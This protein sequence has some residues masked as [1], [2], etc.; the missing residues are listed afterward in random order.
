MVD[1]EIIYLPWN[2][3]LENTGKCFGC[4]DRHSRQRSDP[5]EK[6]TQTFTLSPV[7]VIHTFINQPHNSTVEKMTDWNLNKHNY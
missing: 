4:A 2:L 3:L 1:Y 5:K 7:P 6:N